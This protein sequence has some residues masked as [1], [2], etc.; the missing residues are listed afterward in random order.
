MSKKLFTLLLVAVFALAQF[1]TAS[2]VAVAGDA[3]I[4]IF[5]PSPTP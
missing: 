4:T 3:S 2:A 1:S 5:P